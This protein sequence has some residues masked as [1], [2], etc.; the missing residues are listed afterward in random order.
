MEKRRLA[1]NL[2]LGALLFVAALHTVLAAFVFDTGLV[3]VGGL[4]IGIALVGLFV[5]NL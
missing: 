4:F 1:A 2:L 5:V 3:D